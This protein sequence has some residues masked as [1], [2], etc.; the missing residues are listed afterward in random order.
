MLEALATNWGWLTFRAVL[1]VL[2]GV[3]VLLWPELSMVGFVF[4]FGFYAVAD[5]F[6]A[7]AIAVDVR[8]LSGVG[9]L[10]FE[11]LVRIG[12]GLIAMSSLEVLV[13]FPR[14]FSAWA[15]LTG[16]AEMVVAIVLRRELEGEWPLPFA[17]A[18]S[19]TVALLLLLTPNAVGAAELKWLVGPYAIIFGSTLLALV[20]RLRQLAQEIEA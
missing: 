11:G 6:V 20:R 16:V 13:T 10:L 8:A 19:V 14:F 4:L 9:S 2:Y 17:G 12:G 15:I 5:G 3:T 7:L 18:V 1:S